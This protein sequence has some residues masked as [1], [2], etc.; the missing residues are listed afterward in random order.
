M[1]A[2]HWGG[3]VNSP[4]TYQKFYADAQ[5]FTNLPSGVD[6]ESYFG[7][8]LCGSEPSP[9]TNWQGSNIPRFCSAVYDEIFKQLGKESGIIP[10]GDIIKKLDAMITA[11]GFIE[12]PLINRG[13]VKGIAN[14][15]I[16]SKSSAF[17][18]DLWDIENWKR[19]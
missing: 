1:V 17:D 3:D 4:D 7:N 18:S 2:S 15:V 13:R 14:S 11:K 8:Y 19:G 16:G 5:M 10:R 9:K 12:I 6:P